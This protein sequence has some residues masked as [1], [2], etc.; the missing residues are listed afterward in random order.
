MYFIEQIL[1]IVDPST[2]PSLKDDFEQYNKFQDLLHKNPDNLTEEEKLF[3]LDIFKRH[4]WAFY[5]YIQHH[6]PTEIN[7]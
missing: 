1:N 3:L 4:S 5:Q 6:T 7:I 2:D